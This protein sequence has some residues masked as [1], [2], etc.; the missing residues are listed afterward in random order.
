MKFHR[1]ISRWAIRSEA[2]QLVSIPSLI[3]LIVPGSRSVTNSKFLSL[4]GLPIFQ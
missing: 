4:E 1:E 3:N 2:C